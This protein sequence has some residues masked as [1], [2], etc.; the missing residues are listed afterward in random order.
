MLFILRP[1]TTSALYLFIAM[2]HLARRYNNSRTNYVVNTRYIFLKST[3][4]SLKFE[5]LSR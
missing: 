3:E 5:T 2:N 4:N 1:G